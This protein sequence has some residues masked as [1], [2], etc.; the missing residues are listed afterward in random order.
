MKGIT[1]KEYTGAR[2]PKG[3]VPPLDTVLS[4]LGVYDLSDGYWK[5]L[6]LQAFIEALVHAEQLNSLGKIDSRQAKTLTV[7]SGTA[8]GVY[9]TRQYIEVPSDEVWFLGQLELVTP[10]QSG[11]IVLANFRVSPWPDTAASPDSDGQAF[12]AA[13]QG[14]AGGGIYVAE[15]YGCAPAFVALGDAI[16]APL[17]LPPGSKVALCAEVTVAALAADRVVTLTPYGWKGKRL[18]Q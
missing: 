9:A 8:V 10:A 3:W 13:N 16:G 15:C 4:L 6:P 5:G 1:P 17:R 18:V 12:W 7:P 2:P 11:G 14:Q